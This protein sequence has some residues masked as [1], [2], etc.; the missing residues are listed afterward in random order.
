MDI[1]I[2][3]LWVLSNWDY[4]NLNF[5]FECFGNVEQCLCFNAI[6]ASS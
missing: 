6:S 1:I 4:S 2:I 5:K 3:I